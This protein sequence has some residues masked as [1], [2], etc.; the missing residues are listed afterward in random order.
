MKLGQ[1]L[2]NTHFKIHFTLILSSWL[3]EILFS[4]NPVTYFTQPILLDLMNKSMGRVG[5]SGY[6][7][8]DVLDFDSMWT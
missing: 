4:T 6:S 7:A 1:I 2:T 8:T 3:P 5:D